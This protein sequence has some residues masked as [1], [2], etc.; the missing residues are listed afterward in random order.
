MHLHYVIEYT[1][2]E[3]KFKKFEKMQ[4]YDLLDYA[5]FDNIQKAMDS[6][7]VLLDNKNIQVYFYQL[8]VEVKDGEKTICEDL[9][10]GFK[11]NGQD[12]TLYRENER[13]KEVFAENQYFLSTDRKIKEEVKKYIESKN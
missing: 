11:W 12:W 6:L 2:N 10:D 4:D 13:L 8:W 5:H 1:K 3:E 9:L 7:I